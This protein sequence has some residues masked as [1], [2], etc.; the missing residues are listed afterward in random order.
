M[1]EQ[2]Y[3]WLRLSGQGRIFGIKGGSRGGGGK[4]MQLSVIDKMPGH[5]KPIRGLKLGFWT[6]TQ[7]ASGAGWKLAG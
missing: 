3:Q 7:D 2:V 5:G 1:T 4:K 6:P